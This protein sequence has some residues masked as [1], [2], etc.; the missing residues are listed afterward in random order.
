MKMKIYIT[1]HIS[2]KYITYQIIKNPCNENNV[3]ITYQVMGRQQI[4]QTAYMRIH[5]E[6]YIQ[7]YIDYL[8]E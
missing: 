2:Y 4:T 6:K 3:N 7:I 5:Q 8:I 1:F